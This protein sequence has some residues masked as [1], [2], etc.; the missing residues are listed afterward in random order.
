[1]KKKKK[2]IK[3]KPLLVIPQ[4]SRRTQTCSRHGSKHQTAGVCRV[5]NVQRVS[6]SRPEA[7]GSAHNSDVAAYAMTPEIARLAGR[8]IQLIRSLRHPPC[9]FGRSDHPPTSGDLSFSLID[10]SFVTLVRSFFIAY[11]VRMIFD[12]EPSPTIMLTR[13]GIN[14]PYISMNIK[15]TFNLLIFYHSQYF[16]RRFKTSFV[17]YCYFQLECWNRTTIKF[18]GKSF[19][20]FVIENTLKFYS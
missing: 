14:S 19:D 11:D 4:S 15:T 10:R 3:K 12:L 6:L 2:I 1:M 7:Y 20:F 9:L 5:C 8:W 13:I 16:N 18:L 17:F